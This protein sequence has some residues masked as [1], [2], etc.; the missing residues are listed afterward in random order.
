MITEIGFPRT[1]TEPG[2]S[3]V[4]VLGRFVFMFGNEGTAAVAGGCIVDIFDI[5][6]GIKLYNVEIGIQNKVQ[7]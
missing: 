7:C 3:K 5:E 4:P 2:R 6:Y 1:R